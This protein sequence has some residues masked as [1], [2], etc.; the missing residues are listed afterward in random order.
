MSMSRR[1]RQITNRNVR[2]GDGPLQVARRIALD[3]NRPEWNNLDPL[4]EANI[5]DNC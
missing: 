4:D 1:T 3:A 2:D 5:I